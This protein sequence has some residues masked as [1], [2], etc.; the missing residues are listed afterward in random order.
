MQQKISNAG[1]KEINALN[2]RVA[3]QELQRDREK[4]LGLFL[5]SLLVS[6]LTYRL[7]VCFKESL[8]CLLLACIALIFIQIFLRFSGCGRRNKIEKN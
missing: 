2:S 7:G 8:V 3:M 5:V 6:V 4:I 1:I